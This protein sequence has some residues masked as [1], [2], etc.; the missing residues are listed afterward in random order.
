MGKRIL[1]VDVQEILVNN[2]SWLEFDK[3]VNPYNPE[4][5]EYFLTRNRK[6][7]IKNIEYNKEKL[8]LLYKQKGLCA[9]C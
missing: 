6:S 5:Y 1:L 9:L 4:K 2:Q 8:E 3:A 7:V